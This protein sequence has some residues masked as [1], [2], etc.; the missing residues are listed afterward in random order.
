[1][2]GGGPV[3]WSDAANQGD[4]ETKLRECLRLD[5][6]FMDVLRQLILKHQSIFSERWKQQTQFA[7]DSTS[8]TLNI[9]SVLKYI[10]HDFQI[11]C[12]RLEDIANMLTSRRQYCELATSLLD[13]PV[14]ATR[15]N[16]LSSVAA[17]D[18]MLVSAPNLDLASNL[19]DFNR[20][21]ERFVK[22]AADQDK[23]ILDLIGSYADVDALTTATDAINC[24]TSFERAHALKRFEPVQARPEIGRILDDALTTVFNLFDSEVQGVYQTFQEKRDDPPRTRDAPPAAGGII[25]ARALMTRIENPMML[26]KGTA[27]VMA[28]PGAP[29]T[30]KLYNKVATALVKYES[31]VYREWKS[32]IQTGKSGLK[33]QLLKRGDDRFDLMINM[34][35]AL[36]ELVTE[37]DWLVREGFS[38]PESARHVLVSQQKLNSFVDGLSFVL[39][40]YRRILN[41][42]PNKVLPMLSFHV[43]SLLQ[44]FAPGHENLTWSAPDIDVFLFSVKRELAHFE[45]TVSACRVHVD[46]I[47]SCIESVSALEMV[48]YDGSDSKEITLEAYSELQTGAIV[49]GKEHIANAV[50]ATSASLSSLFALTNVGQVQQKHV[51]T[52]VHQNPALQMQLQATATIARESAFAEIVKLYFQTMRGAINTTG[53]NALHSMCQFFK[54]QLNG[55]AVLSILLDIEHGLPLHIVQ[56]HMYDVVGKVEGH[57]AL[58]QQL[59]RSTNVGIDAIVE[60]LL[61]IAPQVGVHLYPSWT[62]DIEQIHG[63]LEE[64]TA[65]INAQIATVTKQV[66]SLNVDL[67]QEKDEF[68]RI[69]RPKLDDF[70]HAMF[71]FEEKKNTIEHIDQSLQVGPTLLRT[72]TL[73]Y[74]LLAELSESKSWYTNQLRDQAKANLNRIT[75]YIAATFE[76]FNHP[77]EGLAELAGVMAVLQELRDFSITLDTLVVEDMYDIMLQMGVTLAREETESIAALHKECELLMERA[78]SLRHE[79]MVVKKSKFERLLDTEVKTFMVATIHLRNTFESS[80]PLSTTIAGTEAV[81]RLRRLEG[82]FRKLE[83]EQKVLSTVEQLYG[84]EPTPF[85]EFDRTY[86][87]LHM[88]ARLYDLYEQFAVLNST[89]RVSYWSNINL[90]EQHNNVQQISDSVAEL[91]SNLHRWPAYLEM[92]AVSKKLLDVVPLLELLAGSAIRDRHWREVMNITGTTFSLDGLVIQTLLDLDIPSYTNKIHELSRRANGEAELEST[93]RLVDVEWNEQVFPFAPF[94]T[95]TTTEGVVTRMILDVEASQRLIDRAEDAHIN[96]TT[97]MGSPS[98][99]PHKTDLVSWMAKLNEI[100][101]FLHRWL[102][103]QELWKH[104]ASVFSR[105]GEELTYEKAQFTVFDR[106]YTKFLIAAQECHN[107]L[108]WCYGSDDDVTKIGLLENLAEGLDG[109]RKNLSTFLDTKR[110]EF[111]RFNFTS[112]TVLLDV[113]SKGIGRESRN[114]LPSTLRALFSNISYLHLSKD[115]IVEV[116]SA[117]GE[118]LILSSPVQANETRN[119]A[120]LLS[121]LLG[122]VGVSLN[123]QLA[124]AAECVDAIHQK[125]KYSDIDTVVKL[126]TSGNKF[127]SSQVSRAFLRLFWTKMTAR[128]I[129][130]VKLHRHAYMDA[131]DV[132]DSLIQKFTSDL[133]KK[134]PIRTSNRVAATKLQGLVTLALHLR[135]NSDTVASSRCKDLNDFGWLRHCRY[136]YESPDS[137]LDLFGDLDG[138][139][140]EAK[141]KVSFFGRSIDYAG[142]FF[143][144]KPELFITPA[145]AR[146]TFMLIQGMQDVGNIN[147][148]LLVGKPSSASIRRSTVRSLSGLCGKY[149]LETNC[150]HIS[151]GTSLS[152]LLVGLHEDESFGCFHN[153]DKLSLEAVSLFAQ[154]MQEI[155]TAVRGKRF[156]NIKEDQSPILFDGSAFGIFATASS[157]SPTTADLPDFVKAN[158]RPI[159]F[160]PLN[161]KSLVTAHCLAA[162]IFKNPK[163]LADKINL[164][165][166]ICEDQMK[167]EPWYDFTTGSA[168]RVVGFA[169]NIALGAKGARNRRS[170][171]QTGDGTKSGKNSGRLGPLDPAAD[172]DDL[173]FTN[174]DSDNIRFVRPPKEVNQRD[175]DDYSGVVA[176]VTAYRNFLLPKHQALFDTLLESVFSIPIEQVLHILEPPDTFRDAI[177]KT[178]AENALIPDDR[179]V[180]KVVEI[181]S[182]VRKMDTVMLI[183][184]SGSGK[185][186]CFNGLLCALSE[187]G[188]SPRVYRINPRAVSPGQLFGSLHDNE[189]IDGIFPVLWRQIEK[190]G[191]ENDEAITTFIVFD[192]P[193]TE[194]WMA[195]IDPIIA[196][197]GYF[198]LGNGD[199][200]CVPH[201]VKIIFEVSLADL[202]RTGMQHSLPP[203]GTVY[204][205]QNMI[206]PAMMTAVWLSSR[207]SNEAAILKEMI[208]RLLDS[209]IEVVDTEGGGIINVPVAGRMDTMFALL[210]SLLS[211]SVSAGDLLSKSHMECL[212]LFSVAWAFGGL[213]DQSGRMN[214]H[215]HLKTISG[216]VPQDQPTDTIFDYY[217]TESADWITWK[218]E[219]KAMWSGGEPFCESNGFVHTAS[220]AC[221]HYLMRLAHSAGKNICVA[222]MNGS[223]RSACVEQYLLTQNAELS[224]VKTLPC[225]RVTTGATTRNFLLRN[226]ERRTGSVYGAPSGKPITLFFDGA[227]LTPPSGDDE[228]GE[229]L[230]LLLEEGKWFVDGDSGKNGG[231]RWLTD[232]SIIATLDPVVEYNK[233]LDRLGRHFAV[234]HLIGRSCDDVRDI[235]HGQLASGVNEMEGVI[236]T[237]EVRSLMLHLADISTSLLETV[238]E[239]LVAVGKKW[240][241]TYGLSDLLNVFRGICRIP[242]EQVSSGGL[243]GAWRYEWVRVFVD[244]CTEPSDISWMLSQQ[245]EALVTAGLIYPPNQSSLGPLDDLERHLRSVHLRLCDLFAICS[246]GKGEF[247]LW[248]ALKHDT[249]HISKAEF[250]QGLETVEF[251]AH[252]HGPQLVEYLFAGAAEE[253]VTYVDLRAARLRQRNETISQRQHPQPLKV[254]D[255]SEESDAFFDDVAIVPH[256][257]NALPSLV[258]D[259]LEP[260]GEVLNSHTARMQG[261]QQQYFQSH[262][263]C[264]VMMQTQKLLAAFNETSL[265]VSRPLRITRTLCRHLLRLS[266]V[267][268]VPGCSAIM[269]GKNGQAMHTMSRFVAQ[270]ADCTM[271]E[272]DCSELSTFIS[273]MRALFRMAGC[274]NLQVVAYIRGDGLS[275]DIYERLNAFFAKGEIYDLFSRSEMAAL[276]EGLITD[277]KRDGSAL[278]VE[279]MFQERVR[280]NLHVLMTFP[281]FDK[282]LEDVVRDYPDIFDHCYTNFFDDGISGPSFVE[283][284]LAF[285]RDTKLFHQFP[286]HAQESI[287]RLLATSHLAAR[288]MVPDKTV[289]PVTFESF[290]ECFHEVYSAR[291]KQHDTE[292]NRLRLAIKTCEGTREEIRGIETMLKENAVQLKVAEASTTTKLSELLAAAAAAETLSVEDEGVDSQDD[293]ELLAEFVEKQKQEHFAVVRRA[294]RAP[295][296]VLD[297]RGLLMNRAKSDVRV[298]QA[299]ITPK[300]TDTLR[301]L[302]NPPALVKKVVDMVVIVLRKEL[303]TD[304]FARRGKEEFVDSWKVT[305]NVVTNPQFQKWIEEYDP[306][307]FDA[308]LYELLTPY[309]SMPDVNSKGVRR[310]ARECYVMYEWIVRIVEYFRVANDLTDDE[311]AHQPMSQEEADAMYAH[312]TAK[313]N[314]AEALERLQEEFDGVVQHKQNLEKKRA[315]LQSRL[316]LAQQLDTSFG[317]DVATWK[318]KIPNSGMASFDV[319]RLLCKCAIASA[320]VAYTGAMPE[321][322]RNQFVCAIEKAAETCFSESIG[323]KDGGDFFD[324]MSLTSEVIVDLVSPLLQVPVKSW[325]DSDFRSW[326]APHDACVVQMQPY[327]DRWPLIIDPLGGAERWLVNTFEAVVLQYS[328]DSNHF[329][330]ELRRCLIEGRHVI[331]KSNDLA[332]L[333]SDPRIRNILTKRIELNSRLV[334]SVTFGFDELDYN[335]DFRLYITTPMREVII[336]QDFVPFIS[337]VHATVSAHD[338]EQ[339]LSHYVIAKREPKHWVSI[340]TSYAELVKRKAESSLLETRVLD[341]LGKKSSADGGEMAHDEWIHEVSSV[342]AAAENA[343]VLLETANEMHEKAMIRMVDAKQVAHL[344]VAVLDSVTSLSRVNRSY[345]DFETCFKLLDAA[346]AQCTPEDVA[347]SPQDT[348]MYYVAQVY[349]QLSKGMMEVEC[350]AFLFVLSLKTEIAMG[351]VSESVL[352]WFD[353]GLKNEASG[354]FDVFLRT[355]TSSESRRGAPSSNLR[356][357]KVQGSGILN[358]VRIDVNSVPWVEPITAV[359]D[360]FSK[361]KSE[362]V[363]WRENKNLI[364]RMPHDLHD[365]LSDLQTLVVTGVLRPQKFVEAAEKFSRSRFGATLPDLANH[366]NISHSNF[367]SQPQRSPVFML[368]QGTGGDSA[369]IVEQLSVSRGATVVTATFNGL[370]TLPQLRTELELAIQTGVWYFINCAHHN[371]GVYRALAT[372]LAEANTKEIH[373][374]FRLWASANKIITTPQHDG[375][376]VIETPQTFK[377]NLTRLLAL[378]PEDVCACTA[379]PDWLILLHN[380]CYIHCVLQSRQLFGVVGSLHPYTWCNDDLLR[381]IRYAQHEYTAEESVGLNSV[382]NFMAAVYCRHIADGRDKTT[383]YGMLDTWLGFPSLK[384]GYEFHIGSGTGYKAPHNLFPSRSNEQRGI[385][386]TDG[387]YRDWLASLSIIGSNASKLDQGRLNEL[388]G[389][390]TNATVHGNEAEHLFSIVQKMLGRSKVDRCSKALGTAVQGH[391]LKSPKGARLSSVLVQA[392]PPGAKSMGGSQFIDTL[393]N[394]LEKVPV[395]TGPRWRHD[396]VHPAALQRMAASAQ[397]VS[398]N[399]H[400]H[401][402]QQHADAASKAVNTFI[403]TEVA[404][405]DRILAF[406]R[407]DLTAM[408]QY[409]TGKG[410][411]SS[412]HLLTSIDSLLR[413]QVPATW[414]AITWTARPSGSQKPLAA[415]MEQLSLR[416]KELDKLNDKRLKTPSVW[417]GGLHNP[418]GMLAAM[419]MEAMSESNPDPQLRVEITNRDY[420]HLREP[421]MD[422]IFIHRAALDG[423][424]W[425]N[426]GFKESTGGKRSHLPVL[427]LTYALVPE[428][429]GRQQKE[430]ALGGGR[431]GDVTYTYSTPAYRS[432]ERTSED[433]SDLVLNLDV[434]CDDLNA[435]I[436]WTLWG[437][438]LTL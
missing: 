164:V 132:I 53:R 295:V 146:Y 259:F 386:T 175:V 221:M 231:W 407:T 288:A 44:T 326:L 335:D 198:V 161:K 144:A 206:T 424:M 105:H 40:E 32:C 154:K 162:G 214:F 415:W 109:C 21:Y 115:Q 83:Q 236:V 437:V 196:D 274:K 98:L 355:L 344:L 426:G 142:E 117:E 254:S 84:L 92:Q 49:D 427:H 412:P 91:P 408:I 329:V 194:E 328:N 47:E 17:I 202:Q 436:K 404:G 35:P 157:P 51:N 90:E 131:K 256:D 119:L 23:E 195:H 273:D 347:L 239:G 215:A 177:R 336:P 159:N 204:F 65:K 275:A 103:V 432:R 340:K 300:R 153:L 255:N 291:K 70:R 224:V 373:P 346:L 193:F 358:G 270:I 94:T 188:N 72:Q 114:F 361:Y 375:H 379:R 104:L 369:A 18:S 169:I 8:K 368:D 89:L 11:A 297:V 163:A 189:W 429:T 286:V 181:H 160:A 149:L 147:G 216:L 363:G 421:P 155:A 39:S 388:A 24:Q 278:T 360:Q 332:V 357:A 93:L 345:E 209:C 311:D 282:G 212:F 86:D 438:C 41:T 145:T 365:Q 310:A 264:D 184:E 166:S 228:M 129:E 20:V 372:I 301:S 354:A 218:S 417:L 287:A 279:Q 123:A 230:R 57:I 207:R 112:D 158:F 120:E 222:G 400:A 27:V 383:L 305:R 320:Y 382:R 378:I 106:D 22:L 333:W 48:K 235:I 268:A 283:R 406:V 180:D 330:S 284:A 351:C 249:K 61:Q 60:K 210:T 267:I 390:G 234:F 135:E 362:W 243:L 294:S 266:R 271:H 121:N 364:P 395:R 435:Y 5:T 272:I 387:R 308:E 367:D 179:W 211:E 116:E 14:G 265:G 15:S 102:E 371:E 359:M 323:D 219:V 384:A 128:A 245:S 322:H 403:E 178:A 324:K 59:N 37:S 398:A 170:M 1:M 151:D 314:S 240:Q 110:K 334:R 96:M 186:A 165:S 140:V 191:E 30:I 4:A 118:S 10:S 298:W 393:N 68:E 134:L 182:A 325:S 55:P 419:R 46:K 12:T 401:T 414:V 203:S 58:L 77:V 391:R 352:T 73:Q 244:K 34:G 302:S 306:T 26:F 370:E 52:T 233:S 130:R 413:N 138:E 124:V 366:F 227:S 101:S 97:M 374:T 75:D 296:P 402:H 43:N 246:N 143:G 313:E 25:W 33:D 88:L 319:I 430:A 79:L 50:S 394:L 315:T 172:S 137:Q 113:V 76:R 309:L 338:L 262:Y 78:D 299:K 434:Q 183:G 107:I 232:A 168:L 290:I 252:T 303:D 248:D 331:I 280:E 405:H 317:E 350:K 174:L 82:V 201:F 238:Q 67:R 318:T 28:S 293:E 411:A 100:A 269:V 396:A 148:T 312:D 281:A 225:S 242:A 136:E 185:T 9:D 257:V 6:L 376:F 397:A 126:C 418:R 99:G 353:H 192:G 64:L 392:T 342:K 349:G 251:D 307:S 425:E 422:G 380:I 223:G 31:V 85:P 341:L 420:H 316:K 42:V 263:M 220:T 356:R 167:S 226:T 277:A 29:Q 156:A 385:L 108:H 247:E 389:L 36:R 176:F 321:E 258:V 62:E 152:R 289:S 292:L 38:I 139:E 409:L 95:T 74:A 66:G 213:L 416:S 197:K 343:R 69:K 399:A 250:V 87:D 141:L 150:T 327:C 410:G 19:R 285:G 56:P 54:G 80:G 2:D 127:A 423:C 45:K 339:S 133:T 241:C 71:S 16:L 253:T 229:V 171:V 304:V 261:Q 377:S 111:P 173:Y 431:R 260:Y 7:T 200:L 276:F 190:S 337:A 63:A 208:D 381:V 348:M 81:H 122:N 3:L 199:R 433:P 187:F 237:P 13:L 205:D 217:V 125:E 428:A